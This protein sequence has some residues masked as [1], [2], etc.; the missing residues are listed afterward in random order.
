MDPYSYSEKVI[1]GYQYQDQVPKFEEGEASAYFYGTTQANEVS[2]IPLSNDLL[3]HHLIFLGSSGTGK[4]TAILNLTS[5]LIDQMTRDD[6]MI[7]FD[8]KGDYL[9]LKREIDVVIDNVVTADDGL[10]AQKQYWNVFCEITPEALRGEAVETQIN[11]IALT[12][13][14]PRMEKSREK[15][16]PTAGKDVFVAVM[17]ALMREGAG[18]LSNRALNEYFHGASPEAIRQKLS[19]HPDLQGITNYI[20]GE[21][22]QTQGVL[23]EVRQVCQSLFQGNFNM[24]GGLSIRKLVRQR[25]KRVI[26]VEYDLNHGHLLAPIYQLLFDLALKEALSM[27]Q[28]SGRVYFI[29]DEYRL[30]PN[31]RH[32]EIAANFGRSKGVKMILGLQSVSQLYAVYGSS[33]LADSLLS[34]LANLVVFRLNDYYSRLFVSGRLGSNYKK[35]SWLPTINNKGRQEKFAQ[36]NVVE[37]WDI[38]SLKKG[39]SIVALMEQEPFFFKFAKIDLV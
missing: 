10:D 21:H 32:L 34:G 29:L 11:E 33:A 39:E 13:F 12:F 8:A 5:Q 3:S 15:F 27:E 35:I 23:S 14:S 4:T 16:F 30:L 37:D 6:V 7:I 26:F 25:G 1:K 17:R 9:P 18:E 20:S 2:E 22:Q 19:C 38:Y 36:G 31:A 24:S 28:R